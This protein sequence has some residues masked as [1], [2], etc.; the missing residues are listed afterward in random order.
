M[1]LNSTICWN[2]PTPPFQKKKRKKTRVH[3][4]FWICG[5]ISQLG[6]IS[7]KLLSNKCQRLELRGLLTQGGIA[8]FLKKKNTHL[9]LFIP[10]TLIKLCLGF[11][12]FNISC[13]LKKQEA[14]VVIVYVYKFP[15]FITTSTGSSETTRGAFLTLFLLHFPFLFVLKAPS[16]ES[17]FVISSTPAGRTPFFLSFSGK[18]RGQKS[19]YNFGS[20]NTVKPQHKTNL[21]LHSLEWFI[22]FSEGDGSFGEKDGFP[23]FV[24]NQADFKV[25][26]VIRTELGFGRVGTFIQEGRTYGRLIIGNRENVFRLITIFNGNIHLD[27]VYHRFSTWVALYNQA[28]QQNI[29]VLPQQPTQNISLSTGWLS[30]FCEAEGCFYAG[31]SEDLRM[32]QGVRIRLKFSVNQKNELPVL[33]QIKT[34]FQVKNVTIQNAEK[35]YYCV[36]TSTVKSF[37][38]ILEYFSKYKLK[39]RKQQAYAVWARLVSRYLNRT[40]LNLSRNEL[41]SK[42]NKVKIFNQ[43][44]KEQKSVIMLLQQKFEKN[45]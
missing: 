2:S 16:L 1:T 14:L 7:R 11:F 3:N 25:L 19:P 5:K 32:Q 40:H 44:F 36:E 31:Y 43:A 21:N 22:G 20:Y 15:L 37:T 41:I 26:N 13:F 29:Q 45:I 30:G 18:K 17:I 12:F 9:T 42:T 38:L 35:Q 34:L 24:I 28:Y 8:F 27:K 23:I 10:E 4:Q 39:G 33:K 6:P